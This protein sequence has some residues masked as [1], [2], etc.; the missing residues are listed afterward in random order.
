MNDD[1]LKRKVRAAYE[2]AEGTPPPFDDAWA[3]AGAGNARQDRARWLAGAAAAVLVA[4][5]T[6]ALWPARQ[7]NV[8]DD[9]MIA[10]ALMNSTTLFA[11]SDVLLPDRQVYIYGEFSFLASSTQLTEGTLL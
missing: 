1:E 9:Y 2:A 10:D 7:V 6:M 3:A 4:V 11:P 5:V 8:G